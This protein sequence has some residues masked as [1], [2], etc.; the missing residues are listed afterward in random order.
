[1]TGSLHMGHAFQDTLMDFLIRYHK[2]QGNDTLWQV[3]M[4]HAGIA[5]QMVV[6]RQLAQEGKSR[7]DLGREAFVEKIWEWKEKSG[8]TI[9]SQMERL[10]AFADWSRQRFTMDESLCHAVREHFVRLYDDGLIYRGQRLVNWDP[11]FQTAISDL[12]VENIEEEGKLYHIRYPLEN[13]QGHIVVATS[14]PETLFG[15]QAVAV[16]P[17]DPRY[18]HLIGQYVLLPLTDRKL[19]IIADDYVD[20]EFGTGCVKITPAHDFNDYAVGQRHNLELLNIMTR[21]AKLNENVPEAYRGLDRFVARKKAIE[22]LQAQNLLDKEEK[23]MLRIPKGDRS[24]AVIEPYLTDQWYVNMEPFVNPAIRAVETGHIKF[25]PEHYASTFYD[26]MNK[27]QDWC[28]SR[29][30]WWGHRV[31]AFYDEAGNI[32]VAENEAKAREKYGLAPDLALKQDEDVLDTWFSSALWPF[33][34]LGWPE[35]TADLKRY[36]PTSVLVTGF[37]IIFFWVARMIMMGLYCT[38]EVP[39]RTVYVHGLIQDQ[40]G[41]KMSKSK[42]NVLDPIDIIDGIALSDLVQKRTS[43]MMQPQMAERIKKNTEKQFPEGISAYGTDTLRFTFAS[44]ATQNQFLRFDTARLEANRHFCNKIWNAARFVLTHTEDKMDSSV[45][46]T[47]SF[48]DA[49]IE[50]AMAETIQSI[51]S[52]IKDYRFDYVATALYDFTW[53]IFCDWYLELVKPALQSEN[54]QKAMGARITMLRTLEALLRLMHPLMPF[55]SEEIWQKV[56]PV[57]GLNEAFL[58][59]RPYPSLAEFK[60]NP[61]A[62]E[63]VA[64]L[65]Q[66]ILSLRNIRGEMNIAPS[67]KFKVLAEGADENTQA[68]LKK[69]QDEIFF[70]ARVE[71]LEFVPANYSDQQTATA[72]F[73]NLKLHVPLAGLIDFAEEKK[74]LQ[75]QMEKMEKDIEKTALKL[76]NPHYAAKMGEEKIKEEQAVLA[77]MRH[78]HQELA[79]KIA[80]LN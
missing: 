4:D 60:Q 22:D 64:R 6:E 80:K 56:K 15:D 77:Q 78:T 27:L 42:G 14:R 10:G 72:I 67:L 35:D 58:I 39:F 13:G 12:E 52:A 18:T 68:F 19:P 49:Y 31:P 9:L 26:W 30:L 53:G 16:S 32:Y 33:S 46:P 63:E 7:H 28:I 38:G 71:S 5:T 54:I 17:K 75:K 66:V 61:A 41:Q 24:H 69:C 34:T 55:I 51:E 11:V 57:M 50:S 29:Q 8:G 2:M 36:Y 3:G 65:Q 37:D 44:I 73:G 40:D 74:R 48:V 23:H 43:G 1:V 25:V 79:E 20:P 59:E 76:Q 45:T 47:Y 70:L 62:K 21:D